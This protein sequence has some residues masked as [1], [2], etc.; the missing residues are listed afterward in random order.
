MGVPVAWF[1]AR[2]EMTMSAPVTGSDL[3][4]TGKR[5]AVLRLST[6]D[7]NDNDNDRWYIRSGGRTW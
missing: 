4:A 2:T 1:G 7:D 3:V 6:P 5:K